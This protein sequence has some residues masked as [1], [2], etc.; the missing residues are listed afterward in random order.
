MA[1]IMNTMD[2]QYHSLKNSFAIGIVLLIMLTL[3]TS[4][5]NFRVNGNLQ[6][7]CYVTLLLLDHILLI[8]VLLSPFSSWSAVAV[9]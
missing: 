2:T 1:L 6:Q 7:P 8:G 4:L 3:T 9:P 5:K